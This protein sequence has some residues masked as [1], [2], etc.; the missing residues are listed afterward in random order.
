M[1]IIYATSVRCKQNT[2]YYEKK[3]K[4]FKAE[5]VIVSEFPPQSERNGGREK[6]WRQVSETEAKDFCGIVFFKNASF[7]GGS[8]YY[9][10]DRECTK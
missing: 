3:F 6:G 1:E 2:S 7:Y 9:I 5:K 10:K 4:D 8:R